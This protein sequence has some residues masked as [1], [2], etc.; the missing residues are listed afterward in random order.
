[1]GQA[2]PDTPPSVRP[3]EDRL[4]SWKEIATYLKRDVTTVQRWEKREGMPVHRHQ[5]GRMGSV[6]AF[7][8]EIDSWVQGR[9]LRLED[10]EEPVRAETPVDVAVEA[11]PGRTALANRWLLL[12]LAAALGLLACAYVLIPGR[13]GEARP[14]KIKSLA[15]LPLKNLSGDPSQEYLA[16]GTTEALI[17]RLSRIRDLRV[18]SR[19]SVMRFKDSKLSVPEIAK[20][21]GVDAI[22]EG[23]VI[24]EGNRIRV[25]AQLIRG[26]T[27]DHFWSEAYDRELRDTLQLESDVAQSIAR[28]VEV[29]V[30]GEERARVAAARHV[31]P[32]VYE[33]YLKGEDELGKSISRPGFEKS[34]AYFED[35]IAKDATFAP[36]YVGMASAYERLGTILVGASP[37]EARPKVISAARKALE[38]D[39]ELA[40]PHVLLAGVYEKQWQWSDAQAEYKRALDLDPNDAAAHLGFSRWLLYQGRTDEALAWSQR[41]GEL[42]PLGLSGLNNGWI[43][44]HARRYEEAVRELQNVLAQNPDFAPAHW[45]LGFALIANGQPDKAITELEKAVA[46]THGSPAV[47]GILVRAYAHAGRRAEA[48]RLLDELKQRQQKGYVPAAAFVNAYLGLDENE[49]A[50]TWLEKAY[51]EQSNILELIKVHPYFDPLRRDPR[52]AALVYQVGLD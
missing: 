2:L 44:F 21:L 10:E 31:A 12:G 30:S 18:I 23:S 45:Y 34:I 40:E 24:R 25:S 3:P 16:D 7:S 27:D 8:S 51:K 48:L 41:A 20:T 6:Y 35:A 9:R 1:M 29:T 32:E 15:V 43:L 5:H 33:S 38:L 4:D 22:V 14:P 39:P 37:D 13:S 50:L 17:G 49:Q 42:D 47:I 11:E 46:L 36:A 26:A 19:T 52:F 28:R